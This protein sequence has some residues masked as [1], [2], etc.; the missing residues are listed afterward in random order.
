MDLPL[1]Q[2]SKLLSS[3]NRILLT[4]PQSPNVDVVSTAVAWWLFLT[5]QKKLVDIVFD[6][7]IH[8]L[9]YLPGKVKVKDK[10]EDINKFKIVLDI[11]KTKVRQISYDVKDEQLHI[12]I[13]PED[14]LFDEADLSTHK[15]DYKYDLII[16]FGALSL[17]SLG[18]IFDGNRSFFHDVAIINVDRSVLNENFGQLNVVESN[19]TSLAEVS[20]H[21]LNK[22]LDKDIAT[23]LLGGM[24]AATNSF[25]SPQV[26]PK[27]LELASQLI[28]KGA[29]RASIVEALYRTKDISTLKNWGKALSRLRKSGNIISSY[30]QHEEIDN[31]PQDFQEMVKDLILSTPDAQAA[32]IFY[33]L[34]L[35]K[36]EVWVYTIDNVNALELTKDI[37]GKGH[38]HL[39]KINIDKEIEDTRALI[40]NKIQKKLDIINSV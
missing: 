36:T 27:T 28:I 25:Q 7:K 13:V 40:I 22:H 4:G 11:S 30:L 1:K 32:V 39:V 21:V 33:Q 8:K 31:L 23:C 34:E 14:G 12:D 15:G 20:Y 16:S 26:N 19:V 10:L 6:G 5:K 2:F 9:K 17:D 37:E 29:D 35:Y 24:I 18:K 38:R 3:S